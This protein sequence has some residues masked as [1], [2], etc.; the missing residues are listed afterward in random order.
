MEKKKMK[1]WK[2][3]AFTVLAAVIIIPT[4]GVIVNASIIN[5]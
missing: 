2:K 4:V 5:D 3:I 1:L